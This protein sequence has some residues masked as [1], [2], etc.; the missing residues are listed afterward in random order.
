MFP[1]PAGAAICAFSMETSDGRIVKGIVKDKEVAVQDYEGAIHAGQLAGL[2]IHVTDDIFTIS[3][4]SIPALAT[5]EVR[6]E[7]VMN[8]ANDDNADEI[9]LQLSRG[10]GERYG[11]PPEELTSASRPTERT[12]I[13]ITCDI[14]TNGRIN[15]ISSPSHANDIQE[16]RYATSSGRESRRRSTIKYRSRTFLDRDFVLIINA[17]GLD[18]PRCFAEIRTD[19]H[20]T[21]L[22]LQATLVPKLYLP[23]IPAQ[24]YLFVVDRSGSMG[25]KRIEVAKET[26]S[27]LLRMLPAE[28]TTFNVYIFDNTVESLSALSL[29]YNEQS[30][31]NARVYVD[32]ISARGGTEL[33]SAMRDVL[34]ARN[35]TIP[36]AI[37]LLTD[38]EV[39]ASDEPIRLVQDAVSKA[40]P[41][42]ALRVFVLGIG[43][44]ISTATCEGIA[45][46]G[47][48]V[49]LY[50]TEAESILGKCATLFRAGRTPILKDV[51]MDWGISNDHFG[52]QGVTFSNQTLSPRTIG[53]TPPLS[54]QQ[55]PAEINNVHSGSQTIVFAIIQLQRP[56]VPKAVI[57]RGK[58]DNGGDAFELPIPVTQIYLDGAE[59]GLPLIHTHAAWRLIQEHEAGRAKLPLSIMPATD[60]E[61]Q[62]EAIIHLGRKYQIV[63]RHTA[64]VAI[65]SGQDD[66]RSRGRRLPPRHSS[67]EPAL[68]PSPAY[69]N[70]L[71]RAFNLVSSILDW[72][73]NAAPSAAGTM[74]PG[75][76]PV[77]PPPSEAG[78][79]D[80]DA[81][82]HSLESIESHDTF[83]T[84][85]SLNS[86]DCS[87]ES[88]PSSPEFL[89]LTAEEE[90][91]QR[92]PSPR[93]TPRSLPL[94]GGSLPQQSVQP[95]VSKN[96]I[97]LVLLQ[98]VDG[99]FSPDSLRS[100]EG[101]GNAVDEVP[102]IDR[103]VWATA[104]LIVFMRKQM[105]TEN[106]RQLVNDLLAKPIEFLEA[107]QGLDVD[108]LLKRAEE[109]LARVNSG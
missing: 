21:S 61:M 87:D 103:K 86:C 97:Q 81:E 37:F 9:R 76:W 40:R 44:G 55:A 62:K 18:S 88:R 33:G 105:G 26:L 42:A 54:I 108:D 46:A 100:V 14:Q 22:A 64:F 80:Q 25:G 78:T 24:E 96:V 49:D 27:L 20:G 38:G 74:L 1:K 28:G 84:M 3:V 47:N 5:V 106:S 93:I 31:S 94:V 77:S 30:L 73:K 56:F 66:R 91:T 72:G 11:T 48:G 39:H 90:E 7:Y 34:S 99:S 60:N 2:V 15:A 70:P 53:N 68:Q 23:A 85:S 109:V 107:T 36:T 65:D 75:S 83:S 102:S 17:K 35:A 79:E 57:L 104:L 63:S 6:V 58:L 71:Q 32:R 89:P 10:I 50:A 69:I 98:A 4:G 45:R 19:S 95:I 92:Q 59:K 67:P 51:V 101:I 29:P 41:S 13:K 8:L 12:K 52:T 43:S 16:T 82:T